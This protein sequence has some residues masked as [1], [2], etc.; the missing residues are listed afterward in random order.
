MTTG[1]GR[2][3][4]SPPRGW[5]SP[6]LILLL[7]TAVLLRILFLDRE[8][9][10][11]D[12]AYTALMTRFSFGGIVSRLGQ[13]DAPPLFYFLEKIVTTSRASGRRAVVAYTWHSVQQ[14][15]PVF[16]ELGFTIQQHTRTVNPRYQFAFFV[17]EARG[18]RR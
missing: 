10:W 9:L 5:P 7:G 15:F 18:A 1:K 16:E 3:L 6:I 11:V 2:D 4:P 17:L 13:D 14:L 8:G 12:E